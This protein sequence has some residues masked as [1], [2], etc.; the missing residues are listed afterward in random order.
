M[1]SNL[2]WTGLDH[3]TCPPTAPDFFDV[4]TA[5]MQGL[6][7]NFHVFK[8]EI[9]WHRGHCFLTMFDEKRIQVSVLKISF[10]TYRVGQLIND[11]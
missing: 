3:I 5:K 8:P 11:L 2:A 1:I 10:E 9:F 4:A 7:I 6:C